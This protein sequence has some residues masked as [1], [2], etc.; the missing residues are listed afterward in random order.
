MRISRLGLLGTA[1]FTAAGAA[2]AQAPA[3]A[4]SAEDV[5][6]LRAEVQSLRQEVAELKQAQAQAT[7]PARPTAAPTAAAVAA[8]TPSWKGAPQL[9]DSRSGFSFKP[10]GL[11]QFDAGYV[12]IP[13]PVRAGI[14]GG[15]NDQ[16]LGWNTRA[17]RLV[18]GAEGTLPG[19]FGYNLEV[20]F[21]QATVDYEDIYLTWQKA[22]SP[23]QVRIGNFFPLSSL[24]SMTSSRNTSFLERASF[25]DV[26]NE[27]RRLGAT[28]ALIDPKDGYSLTAG[29]FSQE[30]NN[31]SFTRTGWQ[32]SVRGTFSPTIGATR[33]HLGANFQHRVQQRDAQNVQYRARPFTQL[34]DQ[35]FVDT[36]PIAADGDD[37][38]GAEFGLV[39]GPLHLAAEAQLLW[40]RGLRPGHVFAINNGAAGGLFY[41]GDPRFFSGYA[42]AGVYLTGESRAYKGGRWDRTRVRHPFDQGGWGALQANVRFD[43]L[44]LGS[45]AGGGS[46]LAAPDYVDGGKQLGYEA[47]LIWNPIDY[48]RFVAQYAHGSYRGGPRATTVNPGSTAPANV[49]PYA[50][51]SLALRAQVEF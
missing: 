6:A 2:A 44:D 36:G 50:D 20:N 27:N 51:D 10:K 28:V 45:R 39:H 30:I 11:I 42:E 14:V 29:L 17:R 21:A 4:P 40:V 37:I 24:E 25:V 26:Y 38:A 18:I 43:Y 34:T 35:R 32:A 12:A 8:A 15:L 9:T 31:A 23:F 7:P 33:L 41:T 22:G 46:T 16:N 1:A 3:A 49:R 19:G 5:A 13:G 48:I 47:S